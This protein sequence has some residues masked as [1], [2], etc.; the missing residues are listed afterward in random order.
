M[1]EIIQELIQTM[2]TA[3]YE[4]NCLRH[5]MKKCAH[6]HSRDTLFKPEKEAQEIKRGHSFQTP[7]DCSCDN[8]HCNICVGG[9]H[10]CKVCGLA[11]GWLTTE[12]PGYDVPY[13]MGELVGKKRIDF[14]D[15]K[16]VDRE[17]DLGTRRTI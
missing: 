5:E 16:W 3:N 1:Q 14:V 6:T 12:C 7:E 8:E 15:G 10:L 2:K 4:L 17:I 9:L 13:D 11:E